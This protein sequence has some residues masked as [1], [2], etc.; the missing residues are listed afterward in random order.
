MVRVRFAGVQRI[1]D[2]GITL[3]FWLKERI[4]SP[5]FTRVE[6]YGPRDFCYY[7]RVTAPDQLDDTVLDWL[8]EAYAVGVQEW[9]AAGRPGGESSG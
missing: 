9:T 7:L 4:A 3:S 5:R 8:R 2:R 1:S 6:A